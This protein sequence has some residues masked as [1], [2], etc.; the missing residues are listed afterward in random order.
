[1]LAYKKWGEGKMPDDIKSD[2][3]VGKFYVIYNEKLKEH[4]ELEEEIQDM[5]KKWEEGDKEVLKL[6]KL[7]N[8]WAYNGF[9]ETY[10]KLGIN[11]D[12]YYYEN[13]F[14]DKG[15]D[16]V[17]KGLKKGIF[18]K[19]E[20]GNIYVDLEQ[21]KMP[22]KILLRADGTSIYITQD[23]YLA[24]LKFK[25]YKLDESI[26]VVGSEQNLHFQQLFKIL[27]L[28][29]YEWAK[30]CYHLSYGMVY[31]PEGKM[32]SREGTVVD[33]DD[34]IQ[35]MVDLAKVEIRK[36]YQDLNEDEIEKRARIIGLGALKFWMLRV[37][38]HND[39]NYNP[40]ESLSFEGETGPY[41]QYAHARVCAI[42]RKHGKD[43]NKKADLSLLTHDIER[44][45]LMM[46]YNF[47]ETVREAAS[48]H[49]PS[50][51]ARYLLELAQAFNEFYHEC[52]IL[53]EK[54]EL[55]DAR[56]AMISCV[57][58]VIHTGLHLLGIESPEVM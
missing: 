51:V 9:E 58:T 43:I 45:V 40:K 16:I 32:K 23:I 33:A 3:F 10:V 1:M 44:K 31:L 49:R 26:Y 29:G 11:F 24:Q 17:Q 7:M 46:L 54:D 36:R 6:W 35:N 14:Y 4:P 20:K 37:D 56:L 38:H 41:V 52:P 28:L 19:D 48:H 18:Q 42:I 2:H 53:Q 21:Y 22:N 12:K 55:R 15:K 13:E 5:L 27:E 8:S 30:R 25:D 47:P 50:N 39:I 34:F 57:K